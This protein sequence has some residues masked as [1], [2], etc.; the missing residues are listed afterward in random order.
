MLIDNIRNRTKLFQECNLAFCL[1]DICLLL[2]KIIMYVTY[3]IPQTS[4]LSNFGSVAVTS[5]WY[6]MQCRWYNYSRQI[7]LLMHLIISIFYYP[8]LFLLAFCSFLSVTSSCSKI[9]SHWSVTIEPSQLTV[10]QQLPLISSLSDFIAVILSQSEGL[11]KMAL[12]M[13]NCFYDR[14]SQPI[15]VIWFAVSCR[16]PVTTRWAF[17]QVI[18][19]HHNTQLCCLITLCV[20]FFQ[21]E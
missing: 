9:S 13:V 18:S 17:D 21:I 12:G 7:S 14:L 4:P 1:H 3:L 15:D 19:Q 2:S 6:N 16:G 5:A 8:Y 11:G 10:N 20:N